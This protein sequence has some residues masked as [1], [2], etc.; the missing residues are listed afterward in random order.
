M[1]NVSDTSPVNSSSLSE[2]NLATI[3][4]QRRLTLRVSR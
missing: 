3:Y 1:I 2:I 4:G